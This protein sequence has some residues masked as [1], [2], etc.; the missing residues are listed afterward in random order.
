MSA[1]KEYLLNISPSFV[2]M[3]V[4]FVDGDGYISITKAHNKD[5][6]SLTLTIG[7]EDVGIHEI[8]AFNW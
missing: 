3:F 2:A 1:D 6:T 5:N 8:S 7:V 4:G